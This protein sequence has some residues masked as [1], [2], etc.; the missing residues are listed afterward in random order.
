[1]LRTEFQ[2]LELYSRDTFVGV[3]RGSLGHR[4]VMEICVPKKCRKAAV[5][6]APPWGL[7]GLKLLFGN[8]FLRR[9]IM[10]GRQGGLQHEAGGELETC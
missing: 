1:M 10:T 9:G 5:L 7:A 3:A 4:R 6:L 2:T 8:K